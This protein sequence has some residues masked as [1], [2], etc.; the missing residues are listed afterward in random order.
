MVE[1]LE[2]NL[3][4][5]NKNINKDKNDDLELDATEENIELYNNKKDH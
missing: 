5:K 2:E 3:K 4:D 1:R